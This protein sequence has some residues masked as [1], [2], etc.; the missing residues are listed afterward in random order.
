MSLTRYPGPLGADK[1]EATNYR[2][3]GPAHRLFMHDFGRRLRATFAGQTV[4]D[5]TKA[6][7]LHETGLLPQGYVPFDDINTA[8][9]T[10]TEHHTY[11]PF[12]GTASYWSVTVGDRT[13]EN[14][15]WG[16]PEPNQE[17]AWLDGYAGFY[18]DA[19][20]EWY[21]EDERVNG[22]L[23]DPFH[24]VDVRASSRHITVK[25]GDVVLAETTRPRLLSETAMPNRFYI[26]RED[27][28]I[29]HLTPS[30]TQ[31]VCPYKG[32]ASYWSVTANGKTLTDA[33]WSYP[34]AD[35]DARGVS[36]YLSFLHEDITVQE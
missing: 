17:A 29:E 10:P 1:R 16:Y 21:D 35:G 14:A 15:V 20:D 30:Q 25:A 28:R 27:V 34:E 3:D 8:L 32:A 13:A 11:C 26:P 23:R 12:K 31:T 9:L 24:R 22:H 6:M 36:G 2:I 18:W 19:M 4:F 33:A 7:L 5:T